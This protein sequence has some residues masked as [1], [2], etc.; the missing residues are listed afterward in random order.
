MVTFAIIAAVGLGL[1]ILTSF[2]DEIFSFGD[3]LF[4][5]VTVGAG[6]MIFGASGLITTSV[7]LPPVW[8]YATATTLAVAAL[9]LARSLATVARKSESQE[10]PTL[11]GV[12][13]TVTITTGPN[14]GEVRLQSIH[15]MEPRLAWSSHPIP[16]G[17]RVIVVSE[18]GKLQVES[19]ATTTQNE[20]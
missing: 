7:G 19:L 18:S 8:T 3:D 11:I 13:G 6:A 14:G 1:L 10:R 17:T 20:A 4:S 16:S 5:G 2:L 15:E 12:E 9:F